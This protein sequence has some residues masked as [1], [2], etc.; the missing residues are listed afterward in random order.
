MSAID[1]PHSI[2]PS[3][4]A[5][6]A[7]GP[8]YA[9]SGLAAPG[10]EPA[11]T[12]FSARDV[13]RVVKQRKVL[14]TITFCVAYVL[15]CVATFLVYRFAPTYYNEAYIR[16]IPPVQAKDVL[17]DT[18][19]PKDYIEHQLAT[20]ATRIDQPDVLQ[21]VLAQPEI[22][23]TQFYQWYGDAKFDKCLHDLQGLLKALP[24]R[25]TYLVRVG[26]AVRNPS[27]ARL[28]V[29][30][31]VNTYV[32]RSSVTSADVGLKRINSLKESQVATQAELDKTRERIRQL[33]ET[34]DMP[35]IENERQVT[36]D[37]V[38]V[39][40][41]TL[42]ELL[43]RRADVQAQ[44]DTIR[45]PDPR[46]LPIS[47]EMKVI[48]EADPV[49]RY[50]RQQVESMD[51]QMEALRSYSLGGEHRQMQLLKAQ[52]DATFR[53]ETSRREELIDD[54]RS[55]QMESLQQETA[56]IRNM[57][58]EVNEQ[59][60]QKQ[61]TQRDLDGA[62][63][64][65][66]S[67]EKD[68][69][70]LSKQLEAIAIDLREAE[71]VLS[72][73]KR[74]GRLEANPAIKDPYLPSRPNLFIYLGGGFVLALLLGLGLAF[75]REF[76][77][78]AI[79]TPLDVARY[80]HLSVLGCVPL[81]DDEEADID[82][83]ALATRRAPQ[84][85]VA[86]AFRQIR[87]HLTFS[88]PLES[89]RVLL[90]TSP[91]PEDGKTASAVNLAVTFAQGNQRV[92]L[93]DCNFRRPGIRTAF[94][95]TR[96]EG[97]SNVLVGHHPLAHV[98]THTEL[99]NLD[100]VTAGPMP[101]N[102]AELLGSVQMH[103]LLET[104]KKSYDR[105][106][107]DGPPALLISDALVLATQTDAVV[108]VARASSG[109]KGTLRRAREQFQRIGARVIG[110]ILNGVQARP[111]GYFRQQYRDFYEYTSQEILPQELPGPSELEAGPTTGRNEPRT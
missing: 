41:N 15:I 92:L 65:Y 43:A 49:L 39:L 50:Y 8:A 18:I 81:L 93:I 97:L 103:E 102:P 73:Q 76:M 67:Y 57:M 4:P 40:N 60:I 90:I 53:K 72:I 20:E 17:S 35:A 19:L 63:Q 59:L 7:P 64:M 69:D 54:L 61:N 107:L 36:S 27:E 2:V 94:E 77:D 91:R 16:L 30:S 95:K 96:P 100:V 14:I 75:L 12:A 34:R 24:V 5:P 32:Q 86:E 13:W 37:T 58:A 68:E 85:L 105:V 47:A 83:I 33:R 78:Q 29:N 111:R 45:G 109:S 89:Q 74:E 108:M 38:S 71:N 44:L 79:R 101:P 62:I 26:I 98:I 56:R 88:G 11:E 84:S 55:R 42:S 82:D 80:G 52:R 9:L 110:A 23:A 104:A 46:S 106:I 87:A 31:V 6:F 48:I 99:P 51:I 28:I 66:K 21:Q 3:M 22:K 10:T 1:N 25:D 70:R